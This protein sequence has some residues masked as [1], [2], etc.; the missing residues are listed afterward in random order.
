MF[1]SDGVM[2]IAIFRM[3]VERSLYILMAIVLRLSSSLSASSDDEELSSSNELLISASIAEMSSALNDIR[4]LY[5]SE[6]LCPSTEQLH[7]G[8][9]NRRLD[10]RKLQ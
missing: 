4:G 8:E 6:N 10:A 9:L 7:Y 1:L 3:E 5:V 2:T